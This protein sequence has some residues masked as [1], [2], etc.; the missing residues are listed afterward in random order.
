[1]ELETIPRRHPVNASVANSGAISRPLMRCY[2]MLPS[3]RK[4]ILFICEAL[5]IFFVYTSLFGMLEKDALPGSQVFALM[6]LYALAYIAG[7]LVSLIWLPPLLGMIAAGF[8]FQKVPFDTYNHNI[9]RQWA[10]NLRSAA[11]VIILLQA[12]LELNTKKIETLDLV[13]YRLAFLP[14]VIE[15]ITSTISSHF[16]MQLPWS[17]SIMFGFIISGVS[18]TILF[19]SLIHVQER[20]MINKRGLPSFLTATASLNNALSIIGFSAMLAPSFSGNEP[21]IFVA[22]KFITD[23]GSGVLGGSIFGYLFCHMLRSQS[24]SSKKTMLPFYHTALI[25]LGGFTGLFL[26]KKFDVL[27]AGPIICFMLGFITSLIWKGKPQH[28]EDIKEILNVIWN[29]IQ[30]IFFGL[31]GS[32][33]SL[34]ELDTDLGSMILA[35]LIGF[36]CRV[37][38]T[39]FGSCGGH[40]SMKNKFFISATWFS[41]STLQAAAAP[42]VLEYASNKETEIKEYAVKVLVGSVLSIL[43]TAPIGAVLITKFGPMLLTHE[44]DRSEPD[45]LEENIAEAN[46]TSFRPRQIEDTYF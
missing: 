26:A 43:I 29:L 9:S 33:V 15:I 41:K 1:M 23:F 4:L 5:I 46:N 10:F 17:W 22:T 14:C 30:P 6:L 19:P 35:L 3:N 27:G 37:L 42:L 45:P 39:T 12:G 31:V 2:H 24:N 40:F 11:F 13:A 34:D 25:F 8:V 36:E 20:T 7:K 32:E 28:L 21:T 44:N 38:S 16:L 18:S